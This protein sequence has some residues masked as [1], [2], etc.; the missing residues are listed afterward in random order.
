M[1]AYVRVRL[2]AKLREIEEYII[3]YESGDEVCKTPANFARNCE[4]SDACEGE[5]SRC[6]SEILLLF[7]FFF[8]SASLIFL[9][10]LSR[11]IAHLTY[12]RP[13]TKAN[14][15]ENG[16]KIRGVRKRTNL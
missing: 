7:Y 2:Y 8:F 16:Y 12:G 9:S 14:S 15:I 5:K 11:L 4:N 10:P 13:L 3:R 1:F 6:S